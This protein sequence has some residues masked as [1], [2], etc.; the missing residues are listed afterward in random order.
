MINLI[1]AQL[2]SLPQGEKSATATQLAWPNGSILSARMAPGDSPGTAMLM[3]GGFRLQVK[4]PANTS[5]GNVWLQLVNRE[6]PAQ[7]RLLS[8]FKAASLLAEMLANKVKPQ[9]RGQHEPAR[10][11]R[12]PQETGWQKLEQG[13]IPFQAELG[14]DAQRLML[15]DPKDGSPRGV[16]NASSDE[17][18]FLLHGR[19]DLDHFGPVAFA[20]EGSEDKPWML[21]LYAGRDL[22]IVELRPAFLT[23]L[24]GQKNSEE[25][26]KRSH[27]EGKI[28]GGLPENFKSMGSLHG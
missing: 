23:W 11:G 16:V 10:A 26:S 1:G 12:L 28:L 14:A 6:M 15:R 9:E 27:I 4:V 5:M 25:S 22:N 19:A 21:K 8:D 20:L 18:Q 7:F 2:L 24:E 13:Q 17:H 3:L